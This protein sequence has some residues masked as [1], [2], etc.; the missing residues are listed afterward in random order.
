MT[1]KENLVKSFDR[2]RA[3][4]YLLIMFVVSLSSHECDQLIQS[5]LKLWQSHTRKNHV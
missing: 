5:F 1:I 4:G 3:N 2:L